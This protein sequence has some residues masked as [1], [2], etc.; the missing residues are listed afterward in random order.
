MKSIRLPLTFALTFGCLG[1]AATGQQTS[2]L[3]VYAESKE[4]SWGK[5]VG[6]SHEVIAPRRYAITAAGYSDTPDDLLLGWL[7][8]R[9]LELCESRRFEM[10]VELGRIPLHRASTSNK[11]PDKWQIATVTCSEG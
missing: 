9:A 6:V 8:Q 11:H 7:T 3:L 2:G 4:F 1:C 10:N 5:G